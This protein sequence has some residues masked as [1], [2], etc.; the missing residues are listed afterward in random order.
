L[1]AKKEDAAKDQFGNA[2]RMRLGISKSQG[3]APGST[4]HLPAFDTQ[5]LANFFDVGDEIPG[6][7]LF[8]RGVRSAL[9]A[10]ALI[11]VNDAVFF[12]VEEAALFGIGTA[13]GASVEKYHRL[14]AGI[15]AFLEVDLM[16]R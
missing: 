5:M 4:E 2:V 11:E 15:A 16:N 8:Q 10:A 1:F 7:V 12:R 3:R 6:R 9:T 14:A 13:A